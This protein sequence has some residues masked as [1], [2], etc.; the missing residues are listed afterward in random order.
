MTSL[1]TSAL[2]LVFL[3]NAILTLTLSRVFSI[4][5]SL[6]RCYVVD[7][8]IDDVSTWMTSLMTLYLLSNRLFT[9]VYTVAISWFQ[10]FTPT[11]VARRTVSQSG[12]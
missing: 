3:P 2:T 12:R 8:V 1:M 10:L 5:L 6:N 11:F 7:D 4:T 9:L